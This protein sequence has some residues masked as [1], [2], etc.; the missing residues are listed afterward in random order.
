MSKSGERASYFASM[1]IQEFRAAYGDNGFGKTTEKAE[2][3]PV[4]QPNTNE[5]GAGVQLSQGEEVQVVVS[6]EV[7]PEIFSG[8]GEALEDQVTDAAI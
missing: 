8:A 2:E 7:N 4:L 3:K 1:P 6:M 5:E